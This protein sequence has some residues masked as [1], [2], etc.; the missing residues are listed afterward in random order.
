MKIIFEEDLERI[1]KKVWKNQKPFPIKRKKSGKGINKTTEMSDY[2]DYAQYDRA[3]RAH[4]FYQEMISG[5]IENLKNKISKSKGKFRV[6]EIG[7]GNGSLTDRLIELQNIKI[8]ATDVDKN[9]IKFV[10]NRLKSNNLRI[11]RANALKIRAK[12]PFDVIIASWNYE[13]I[14]N[15]KNGWKLGKSIAANLKDDGIYIEGAE[16]VGP[17]KNEE[18][19][20]RTFLDYHEDIIDRALKAGNLDTAQIEYGALVSGLTGVSH[21]KRDKDTHVNEMEKGGLRLVIWKKFGPFTK[22]VGS[23]G[24]YLFIFRKGK[25]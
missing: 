7:C 19:R 2:F 12:N 23:A 3:T 11:V 18:E 5:M 22:K 15:Y 13:H 1:K 10:E 6:L 20:Q 9:S 16:L 4:A 21:F 17:F 25:S 14:T 24:N 8:L